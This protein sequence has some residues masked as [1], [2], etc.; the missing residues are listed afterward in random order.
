MAK[1]SIL[2][3]SFSLCVLLSFLFKVQAQDEVYRGIQFGTDL[4][5]LIVPIM[6]STQSPSMEF[7]INYEV[8]ND[9]LPTFEFGWNNI[10]FT[11]P[12]YYYE[13]SGFYTRFGVDYNFMKHVDESNDDMFYVGLRYGYSRL[14]HEANNIRV[15]DPIYGDII[16]G[17][18]PRSTVHSHWAEVVTGIHVNVGSRFYLGWK[19]SFRNMISMSD[20]GPLEP[21]RIP[22]YGL[23]WSGG[24]VGFSYTVGY[25]IPIAIKIR[26]EKE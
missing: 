14:S 5:R 24:L 6:D 23:G 2:K 3:F 26:P 19:V 11:D 4:S 13:G 8:V 9:V 22:G 12:N 17:N 15:A 7:Y 21:Y 18:I 25:K 1:Q 16:G 10:S 20:Y